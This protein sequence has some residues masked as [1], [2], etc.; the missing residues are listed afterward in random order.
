MADGV[1]QFR[2]RAHNAL[3]VVTDD[4][5]VVVDP[6]NPAAAAQLAAEIRRVAPGAPLRAV[7]YSHH[8]ADHAS[9]AGVLR[10]AMDAPDAPII[11]HD[12]AAE[13]IAAEPRDDQPPPTVTFS[14]RMM[15]WFGGRPVELRYLGPSHSDNLIVAYLHDVGVAF[16]VDFVSRDRVGYRDLGSVHFPEQFTAIDALLD[17]PFETVV[18]GHGPPGD[19]AAVERQL[20]YYRDLRAAVAAAVA[21]G[22]SED[23][24]AERVRLP[25]YAD[26]SG[27]DNWFALNVRGMYRTLTDRAGR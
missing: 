21:E 25:A 24:A 15:L 4:G 8:H 22:L 7:V 9:G 5:V 11:A 10:Q 16:A 20:T 1:Y 23:E 18:F 13:A 17:L 14:D 12:L 19:R 3:F 2:W 27:Y 6:I 26:W